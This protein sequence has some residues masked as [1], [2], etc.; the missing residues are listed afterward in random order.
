MLPGLFRIYRVDVK[1]KTQ[2]TCSL[3][4]FLMAVTHEYFNRSSE[5]EKVYK[6]I[7]QV[8]DC[9][10]TPGLCLF[11][12]AQEESGCGGNG[13][14]QEDFLEKWEMILLQTQKGRFGM[15]VNHRSHPQLYSALIVH[16]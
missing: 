7:W 11:V 13:S 14:V 3:D 6:A 8:H 2:Y 10:V 15:R 9:C 1:E 16:K 5:L 12:C 4:L